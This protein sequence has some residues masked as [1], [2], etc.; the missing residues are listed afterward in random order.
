MSKFRVAAAAAFFPVLLAS[1]QS[2]NT[3]VSSFA[4]ANLVGD[5]SNIAIVRQIERSRVGDETNKVRRSKRTQPVDTTNL[6]T[7]RRTETNSFFSLAAFRPAPRQRTI[8]RRTKRST[9]ASRNKGFVSSAAFTST[10]RGA[11]GVVLAALPRNEAATIKRKSAA[12]AAPTY[13]KRVGKKQRRRAKVSKRRNSK[14]SRARYHRLIAK[15]ARA[16]GVP[17]K[18]AMAVVQVESNYR[19]NARGRAGEIGLMQLMPRTARGIGYR[20]KLKNLYKPDTNIRYG[21]KYLGKAYRLGGR[22]TCGAIL[23]YNAGHGAKRMN[24]ISRKY[25]ARV[26]RIMRRSS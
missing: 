12:K 15:H 19:A 24:P 25:C 10:E 17:I 18:L 1:C 8:K 22:K 6:T 21:M 26:A 11:G 13:K 3:A 2:S 23:K 20:G 5:R 16:N 9:L 7:G 4:G 14:G